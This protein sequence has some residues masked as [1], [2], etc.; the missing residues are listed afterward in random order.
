[1]T[2]HRLRG[3]FDPGLISKMEFHHFDFY[4]INGLYLV[5]KWFLLRFGE[6]G[7]QFRDS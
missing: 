3:T 4:I 5:Y 1:M 7:I 2:I 6:I